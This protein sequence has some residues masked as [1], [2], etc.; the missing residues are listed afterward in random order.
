MAAS[1][2]CCAPINV[3]SCSYCSSTKSLQLGTQQYKEDK[4]K[5]CGKCRNA[6]YCSSKCQRE[7]WPTHKSS[8]TEPSVHQSQQQKQLKKSISNIRQ[9]LYHGC[10]HENLVD[11]F[12]KNTGNDLLS[13]T[14]DVLGYF[15]VLVNSDDTVSLAYKDHQKEMVFNRKTIEYIIS[16]R[17]KNNYNKQSHITVLLCCQKWGEQNDKVSIDLYGYLFIPRPCACI[18]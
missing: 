9:K 17:E 8:C 6:L 4:L 5:R 10:Y 1:C 18:K 16:Q 2:C 14:V 13:R 15:V 7:H 12:T 3:I 11:C